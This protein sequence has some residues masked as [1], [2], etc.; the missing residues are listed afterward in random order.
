MYAAQVIASA[1]KNVTTIR[2]GIEDMIE[3]ARWHTDTTQ[4][5]PVGF[6]QIG[7]GIASDFPICVLPLKERGPTEE[8][9]S[10]SHP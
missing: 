1:V 3:L 9:T 6:F 4:K 10:P 8:H 5:T 2:A 7:G